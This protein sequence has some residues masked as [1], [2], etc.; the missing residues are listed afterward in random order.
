MLAMT[1]VAGELYVC[2]VRL[3]TDMETNKPRGYAFIEYM[4]TRDMKNAYKQADGR[5]VDNRRVLVDVERGRT[6]PNWC[7]RRLGGGLGS[8]RIGGENAEQKLS[9]REQQH[10][11]RPRSEE[12]RKDDRRAD[13]DQEKSRERPRERDR[14]EKIRE[15]SHEQIWLVMISNMGII[16]MINTKAMMLMRMNTQSDMSMSTIKCNPTTQNLKV[17]RKG[18]H[19][20]KVTTSITKLMSTRIK[21]LL[22]CFNNWRC[23]SMLTKRSRS[24]FTPCLAV[25]FC[26][27]AGWI[28]NAEVA[29]CSF[30]GLM[31]GSN[32]ALDLV[33]LGSNNG[34]SGQIYV[35]LCLR[36]LPRLP[37]HRRSCLM[38]P[39]R[40]A[41]LRFGAATIEA[42]HRPAPL[43]VE[44]SRGTMTGVSPLFLF[45]VSAMLVGDSCAM[46]VRVEFIRATLQR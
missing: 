12:P 19:T 40:C 10:A 43:L 27:F 45:L 9:A 42:P 3:V 38:P 5:K 36:L 16:S 30:S 2:K 26:H 15:R 8:S 29:V 18:K 6:V 41:G 28:C 20:R 11:G 46:F 13:R 24:M 35:A 44:S 33:N 7:P 37:S 39:L 21:N 23:S 17:L 31:K 4:H 22:L 14:D 34:R 1:Q 25:E 32:E